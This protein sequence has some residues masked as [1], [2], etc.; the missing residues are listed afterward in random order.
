MPDMGSPRRFATSPIPWA[1]AL[2]VIGVNAIA[3]VIPA[4]AAHFGVGVALT[5]TVITAFA[6]AR[7]SVRLV[8]GRLA[9]RHGSRRISA[10]GGAI[11][12][13]GALIAAFAPNIGI[14]LGA[15]AIQGTGSAMFGTSIY[16]Y[17]LVT[18]EKE[19]LGRATAWYQAG[20]LIGTTVGPLLGGMVADLF[21]IFAPFYLQMVLASVV[22]VVSL[23]FLGESTIDDDTPEQPLGRSIVSLLRIDGFM[24][25]LLLGFGLF[26][27]RAGATNVLVPVFGDESLGLSASLI[28][29]IIS[30]GSVVSL[31]AMPIAGRVADTVGR[32]PVALAGAFVAALAVAGYGL[33]GTTVQLAL[34]AATVGL[35]TGLSEVAVPTMVGDAAPR[36]A[37]GIVSAVYRISSDLGWVVGP[38]AL[39]LLADSGR[40]GL[41][42]V[43]AGAP[44][45]LGGVILA[46]RRNAG[47]EAGPVEASETRLPPP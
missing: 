15:R 4:Y 47:T 43:V 38:I 8:A 33:T 7:M 5:S 34:V 6:V 30:L 23:R 2:N 29:A 13:G 35:G 46:V 39:G 20:I 12:A 10:S 40:F 19:D 26:F 1:V 17:M 27:I 41:A 28:G 22:A 21:G 36:G 24:V 18:T 3:P 44:L 9:D 42:F 32:V 31:V 25:L 16:R 45:F 11:Q 37:E 14:L